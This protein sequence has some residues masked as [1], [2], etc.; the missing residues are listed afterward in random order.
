MENIY[1]TTDIYLTFL[2][3]Y[4]FADTHIQNMYHPCNES[5]SI[6]IILKTIYIK[7]TA[8]ISY[9]ELLLKNIYLSNRFHGYCLGSG[10]LK[11]RFCRSK[12]EMNEISVDQRAISHLSLLPPYRPSPSNGSFLDENS[13]HLKNGLK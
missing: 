10:A 13:K 12:G 3:I 8:R 11:V 2:I 1:I 4:T 7:F 5:E 9:G 6:I